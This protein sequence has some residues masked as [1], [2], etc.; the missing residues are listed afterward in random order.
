MNLLDA[1][2]DCQIGGKPGFAMEIKQIGFRLFEETIPK[3]TVSGQRLLIALNPPDI[4][5]ER[6]SADADADIKF[7]ALSSALSTLSIPD[8]FSE[9]SISMEPLVKDVHEFYVGVVAL[10]DHYHLLLDVKFEAPPTWQ[11][12]RKR[13]DICFS[14]L[15]GAVV[16]GLVRNI[17]GWISHA[18]KIWKDI[19]EDHVGDNDV[20]ETKRK[21]VDVVDFFWQQLLHVG[22]FIQFESLLSSHG[23]EYGMLEDYRNAVNDLK[24]RVKL[25]FHPLDS[26]SEPSSP[27]LPSRPTSITEIISALHPNHVK[28]TGTRTNLTL[29]LGIP[30]KHFSALPLPL[31]HGKTVSIIPVLFTQGINEQQSLANVLGQTRLQDEIN[32]DSLST[33]NLYVLKYKDWIRTA[34]N[35]KFSKDRVSLGLEYLDLL[36]RELNSLVTSGGREKLDETN[37]AGSSTGMGSSGKTWA[38]KLVGTK[39]TDILIIADQITRVLGSTFVYLDSEHTQFTSSLFSQSSSSTSSVSS[40]PLNPSLTLLPPFGSHPTTTTRFISCKSA[41]D[42]TAMSVTL[43]Q[44]L[45]IQTTYGLSSSMIENLL[46]TMRSEVGVRL[47]NV[48]RNL[49]PW[50]SFQ[51]SSFPSFSSSSSSLVHPHRPSV[52]KIPSSST[53]SH[54]P[55]ITEE[56]WENVSSNE[57]NV[58]MNTTSTVGTQDYKKFAFTPFQ[59]NLIPKLYR[60][61]KRVI[62]GGIQS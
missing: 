31:Q 5:S 50:N 49:T 3:F 17:D 26:V 34:T 48:E 35:L 32:S 41:K 33:L 58:A 9:L 61:P 23:N 22:W 4:E 40:N 19:L 27:F 51:S 59:W 30:S 15:L 52:S 7:K 13:N 42:R 46:N 16:T 43:E 8:S 44:V 29:S 20:N 36:V 14:Q 56:D 10:I 55:E 25:S 60:P 45:F 47:G 24:A 11:T 28:I 6:Q 18:E 37:F 2:K 39:N 54:E 1:L 57:I 38:S 21:K 62:R 53:L 12:T